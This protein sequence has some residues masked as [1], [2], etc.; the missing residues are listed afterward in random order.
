M[1]DGATRTPNR[2][3][4]AAGLAILLLGSGRAFGQ[5]HKAHEAGWGELRKLAD[6]FKAHHEAKPADRKP[7]KVKD[8][9]ERLRNVLGKMGAQAGRIGQ[10]VA[11]ADKDWAATQRKRLEA[12]IGALERVAASVEKTA[13]ER[14]D[15]SEPLKSLRAAF[16]TFD[17]QYRGVVSAFEARRKEHAAK[18]EKL[19][20]L[21][22][23]GEGAF[24]EVRKQLAATQAALDAA[25]KEL[26][27]ARSAQKRTDEAEDAAFARL[28]AAQEEYDKALHAGSPDPAAVKAKADALAAASE[29]A[30]KAVEDDEKADEAARLAAEEESRLTKKQR[31]LLDAYVRTW[32]DWQ[33]A[34]TEWPTHQQVVAK[35]AEEYVPVSF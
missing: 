31:N 9:C 27:E 13:G 32:T 11:D 8:G 26:A 23:N 15:L 1:R 19:A 34:T 25:Q 12:A 28:V 20:A 3:A 30:R 10:S 29:A 21:N 4:V 5:L 14:K 17:E 7:D 16:S 2:I 35:F 33:K 18:A 22:R 24:Q 6:E